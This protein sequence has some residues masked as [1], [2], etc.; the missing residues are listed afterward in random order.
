MSTYT[1][2]LDETG[3]VYIWGSGKTFLPCI[4]TL[5][6]S[7]RY[8]WPGGSVGSLNSSRRDI[9]PK[10]L[11]ALPFPKSRVADIS[12]G[13]GHSLFLTDTGSVFSWG[14]GANGRLGLGDIADHTEACWVAGVS[15]YM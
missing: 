5:S 1:L 3:S 6:P 14:N 15:S 13:L 10:L 4:D 9:I 11:D 7:Y 2:A 12:C 8:R